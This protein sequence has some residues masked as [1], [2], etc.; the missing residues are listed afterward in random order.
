MSRAADRSKRVDDDSDTSIT[1]RDSATGA[2]ITRFD[3]G[4]W[5]M[6]GNPPTPCILE[7]VMSDGRL[8]VMAKP[9]VRMIGR[10]EVGDKGKYKGVAMVIDEIQPAPEFDNLDVE[11]NGPTT[12]PGALLMPKVDPE[13]DRDRVYLRVVGFTPG[14]IRGKKAKKAYKRAKNDHRRAMERTA[15]KG[16]GDGGDE[17]AV[18]GQPTA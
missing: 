14:A 11:L 5:L 4:V 7:R 3:V 17:A 13:M 12:I 15:E 10:C 8:C 2:P 16:H 6:F 18:Q 9:G 1:L